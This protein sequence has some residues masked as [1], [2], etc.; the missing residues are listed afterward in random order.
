[1]SSSS[2]IAKGQKPPFANLYE[3]KH[4]AENACK[5]C[6]LCFKP[7]NTV[8]ITG[9]KKDWFYVCDVHLKDKN[10]A[11]LVYCNGLGKDTEAEWRKLCGTVESL[12]RE[13]RKL[14]KKERDKLAKEKSW[15]TVIPSWGAKKDESLKD[16]GKVKDKENGEEN[17]STPESEKA[18]RSKE[19]VASELHDGEQK[20]AAFERENI[21]YRLEQ[22]FYRGRLLQDFKRKKQAE[23]EQK[24]AAGTLFP[25]LDG[26]SSLKN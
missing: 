10:F 26:L 11:K 14:E 6:I 17:G 2:E 16:E 9:D 25:T 5:A 4:V 22:V 7:T 13:L 23:I 20:L 18:S 3:V 24:L 19:V 8:L 12:Q 21:K 1:M 15:L